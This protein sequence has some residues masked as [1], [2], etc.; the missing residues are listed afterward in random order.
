[1]MLGKKKMLS[2]HTKALRKKGHWSIIKL[3]I[4]IEATSAQFFKY[5]VRTMILINMNSMPPK[6]I[7]RKS[8]LLAKSLFKLSKYFESKRHPNIW[9]EESK[10][11]RDFI[12]VKK[13]GVHHKRYDGHCT[14]QWIKIPKL[15]KHHSTY[16]KYINVEHLITWHL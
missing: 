11:I 1:M 9:K 6:V 3:I 10:K 16:E 14:K 5:V 15:S 13:G 7:K 4:M 2:T 8:C 12:K